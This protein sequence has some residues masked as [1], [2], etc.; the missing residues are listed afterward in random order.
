MDTVLKGTVRYDGTNFAGWQLQPGRRTVQGD[1]EAVMA[2]V[3]GRAIRIQGAGRTDAGVHA[4]GQVFSCTW[5]GTPPERLRHALSSMLSPDIRITQ[6]E[7][8]P[9]D[10]NARF[11]ARAKRYAYAI[12]LAREPDPLAARYAWHVA[13]QIDLDLIASLLP[14]LQGTHDFAG[15]QSAGSQMKTTVR[16]VYEISLH[17]GGIAGPLDGD[18]LWRF[19]FYGDAFLYKMVRNITGSLIEIGRGRFE[20]GFLQEAL[21]NGGPFRGHC[22]PPQGLALLRVEY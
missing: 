13:F 15:F 10:F 17:R 11:S 5:P 16:T 12:D 14:Q 21:A 3:A 22:A 2:R 6:L 19:E 1:I 7:A 4:L 20:P 8:A 9:A 18:T